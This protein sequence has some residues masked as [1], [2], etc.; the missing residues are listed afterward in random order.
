VNHGALIA[1]LCEVIHPKKIDNVSA[2]DLV[3]LIGTLRSITAE[4]SE[5]LVRRGLND[6]GKPI[7]Q[8]GD[9]QPKEHWVN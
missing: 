6:D 5:E 8:A 2:S 7:S 9:N 4:M 1:P 3:M